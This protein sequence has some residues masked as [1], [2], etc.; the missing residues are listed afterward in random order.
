MPSNPYCPTVFDDRAAMRL[1]CLPYAGGG[2]AVFHRWRMA[3]PAG[4]ELAPIC[5]PGREGRVDEPPHTEWQTLVRE[6]A[7]AIASSIDRPYALLGHSMGAW[8]AFELARELRR[9]QLRL[10]GLLAVA[11]SRA[12][13]R[14][15]PVPRLHELPDD[16][17]VRE[18]S[19]RFDGI[20]PA[21]HTNKELLE[22]LL[23]TLR[24]DI[25]L[26][27]QYT[28]D[29][30]RPLEVEILA[31]GGTQDPAVSATDLAEWRR[32]TSRKFSVRM[33]PGGHFFLFRIDPME[34]T[35][36]K[37]LLHAIARQLQLNSESR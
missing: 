33:M 11:A 26:V 31:I 3:L 8:I 22:L 16:E 37:A 14:P 12:P 27:E 7:D 10:P 19:N 21:V 18:L 1:F 29:D 23:P 13:H 20:P 17:F 6:I 9:R 24:A 5:L 25:Q 15:I 4:M 34:D 36:P 30:E 28:F 35:P 32:H 2:S